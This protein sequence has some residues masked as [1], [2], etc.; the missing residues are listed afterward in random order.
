MKIC[1]IPSSITYEE[2]ALDLMLRRYRKLIA[3]GFIEERVLSLV[4]SIKQDIEPGGKTL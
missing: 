4:F 2:A 3:D 1:R